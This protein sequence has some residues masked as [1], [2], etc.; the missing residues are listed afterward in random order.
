MDAKIKHLEFIQSTIARMAH[1]SFLLKGWA[2]SIVAAV[3]V[4]AFKEQS[5]LYPVMALVLVV[6]FW[7][8]DVY[9]LFLEKRF[10][11]LYDDVRKKEIQN[12]DFSM[13]TRQY[14]TCCECFESMGSLAPSLFYGGLIVANVVIISLL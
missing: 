4:I 11:R 7:A 3:V 5:T 14:A 2:V 1:A 9:Y 8:L 6:F 12:I 13:D 10:R